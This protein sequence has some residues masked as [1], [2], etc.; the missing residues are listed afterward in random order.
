M[1]ISR[2][3]W[4]VT[5]RTLLQSGA[6]IAAVQFSSPF[7]IKAR[8]ETPV[9]I[10]LVDPLTGVYAAIAQSEVVG[11]K[12][13]VEEINKAGGILGR[14]IELLVEDSANDVGTGVQKTRKLI[15]RDQVSFI[16]GDVNS[17]IAIA[18]AQVTSEKK[19]L[20]IVSGGHTDAVTGSSCSW[21]VFRVCNST[22][23]DAAAIAST[24]IEKFGK[25]WYF[26]TP[27]YAY[28]H[29][30][31]AG[32]EK[33]LKAAG[34]TSAGSLVPLGTPDYSAYLIQA[35][36]FN[37]Q[38]LINVMGGG[39][40]VAS[41]K[42][43]VQFGLDK[44]MAVG[45]ALFELESIRSVPD[46]ARIGWWTMEWWWD[47]PGVP[48]VAEFNAAMKKLTGGAATARNWFGYVSVQTLA[49]IAN[50]EKTLD[51]P[52]LAHALSGFKLP[53]DVALQPNAPAYR[54]G[55]HELMSTVFVGEAHPPQGD[56]DNMFTVRNPVAGEKA[57][58]SVEDK[59]CKIQWP[60]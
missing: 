12:Y 14:P 60:A 23:M 39:D 26:L 59:G 38:V 11:A 27:D 28:G 31:Q 45:G 54:A 13:A 32:F 50:Q 4:P 21:N 44:Q 55:D 56:P 9:R 46:T 24:L 10:G 16:I 15:E 36:A 17:G 6:A 20:H 35:K 19:V 57:A 52:K 25:K 3:S 48:H 30:V 33:I 18:M 47:Q 2:G 8:G 5:R 51:A 43:F 29:S 7:I 53:P 34:G 1:A 42:Q 22:T 41:L 37:P 58:G 49:L 40:Q